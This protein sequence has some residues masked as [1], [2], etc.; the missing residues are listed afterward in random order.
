MLE[1]KLGLKVKEENSLKEACRV[2]ARLIG[3]AFEPEY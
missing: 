2:G 3:E 1:H